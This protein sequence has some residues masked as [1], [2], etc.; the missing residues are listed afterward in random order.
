MNAKSASDAWY[1]NPVDK[2]SQTDDERIKDITVLP[3]P[4]HLIRFFPISGTPVEALITQTRNG[5]A[6]KP[7]PHKIQG[8]GANFIPGNLDLGLIDEV[9]PVASVDAVHWARRAMTEE[10]ILCGI[11][12]GAA[13]SAAARVAQR[14]ELQGKVIVVVLPDSGER[15]LS[16]VLFEGLFDEQGQPL[17]AP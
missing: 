13:L 16:S 4:E 11:S 1:A 6:L 15:Y 3:P 2:T 7:A 14:P 10:G 12:C 5:E 8:I 17:A 9:I